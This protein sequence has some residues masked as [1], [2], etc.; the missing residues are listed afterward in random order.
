VTTWLAARAGISP[1]E[2]RAVAERLA[3]EGP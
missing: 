2:A 1:G 3:A